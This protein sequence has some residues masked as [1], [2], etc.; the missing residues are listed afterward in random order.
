[1]ILTN[2]EIKLIE[3]AVENEVYNLQQIAERIVD[4]AKAQDW[5]IKKRRLQRAM[6]ELKRN[7]STC[8][9]QLNTYP[10]QNR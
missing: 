9:K 10:Y 8:T 6:R 1:M 4:P 2:E 7:Y 3:Q 5:V